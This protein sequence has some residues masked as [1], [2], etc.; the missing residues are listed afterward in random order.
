M[1][2]QLTKID[3]EKKIFKLGSEQSWNHN[4][5]L[6]NGIETSPKHQVSHGK[7]LV[8][9]ER[10]KTILELIDI[11]GKRVLDIG[12]NEGFFSL[13]MSERGAYVLG[14][15]ID[16]LRI[17]KA[18]FVQSILR[19]P[20]L[21]FKV[22]DIYSQEFQELDSF[23]LCICMGFL[24]RVP[25]PYSAVEAISSKVDT[26]LFEWKTLKH[27]HHDEPYAYF[28]Q[29]GV[30][31]TDYYGTEYWL[32]SYSALELILKRQGFKHFYRV[33]DPR[34]RRGILVAG[35]NDNSVFSATDQILHRGRF[36]ALLSHTKRYLK[37]VIGILSGRLNS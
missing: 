36:P 3:I 19:R 34:Q 13:K 30:D 32:L 7:N 12:C 11:S 6:S 23:D 20:N 17:K 10:I 9:W 5:L 4:I 18:N 22:I 37:T 16:K 8:K 35:K 33:D 1:K 15:D 29:K 24:H 14:G 2:S 31:G 21:E 25:D 26:I 28:T 27:G